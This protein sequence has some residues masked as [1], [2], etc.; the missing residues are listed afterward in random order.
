ME[1]KTVRE[2]THKR[3]KKVIKARCKFKNMLEETSISFKNNVKILRRKSALVRF[4]PKKECSHAI[5]AR[6]LKFCGRPSGISSIMQLCRLSG[7]TVYEHVKFLFDKGFV[8][9]IEVPKLKPLFVT[10][11]KGY[12]YLRLYD[13][14]E[15]L[16]E[17][18]AST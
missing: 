5:Y 9:K 1:Y 6:I 17:S 2:K 16:I 4:M 15:K 18:E 13:K 8:D 14:L 7:T 12:M 10:T 11:L 3:D